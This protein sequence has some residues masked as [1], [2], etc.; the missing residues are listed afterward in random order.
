MTA[1]VPSL[2]HVSN[3]KK[4]THLTAKRVD[5]FAVLVFLCMYARMCLCVCVCVCVCMLHTHTHNINI[6]WGKQKVQTLSQLELHRVKQSVSY[7]DF[8][9]LDVDQDHATRYEHV[10]LEEN[11]FQHAQFTMIS[12]KAMIYFRPRSCDYMMYIVSCYGKP[13]S[14]MSAS[15]D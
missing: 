14:L 7:L 1:E 13:H 15:S 3:D 5:D 11:I 6:W 8:L 10:M 9:N 12:F 2:L 4:G